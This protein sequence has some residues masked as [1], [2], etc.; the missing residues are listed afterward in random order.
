MTVLSC[1]PTLLSML[2]ED[3]PSL[4]LL[5]LGGEKCSAQLIE[6]WARPGRRI[7]NTYGPTETTVIAT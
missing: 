2:D 4:R 7:V 1:V 5:I 6:K 3:V